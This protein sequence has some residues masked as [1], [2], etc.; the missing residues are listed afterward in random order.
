[1]RYI[2]VGFEHFYPGELEGEIERGEE[3]RRMGITGKGI[4]KIGV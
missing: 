4:V 1:M 3:E 2:W